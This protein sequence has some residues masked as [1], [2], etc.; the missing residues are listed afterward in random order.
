M[1]WR[2]LVIILTV[3][4]SA[5]GSNQSDNY[6]CIAL[7]LGEPALPH[8]DRIVSDFID[9]WIKG[10]RIEAHEQQFS[11]FE[12]AELEQIGTCS[13]VYVGSQTDR[14]S[15][16]P[17]VLCGSCDRGFTGL[18]LGGG[19]S[20]AS[21]SHRGNLERLPHLIAHE[22]GHSVGLPHTCAPSFMRGAPD[23]CD[24]YTTEYVQLHP[25]AIMQHQM[26]AMKNGFNITATD[27]Q[28]AG[29]PR[30]DK[31]ARSSLAVQWRRHS[32]GCSVHE[33]RGFKE[34]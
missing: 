32:G 26:E 1:T 7:A 18:H 4:L 9:V 3:S 14:M 5:C 10:I 30:P 25:I 8:T 24:D 34:N 28:T 17:S 2:G 12:D 13:T 21:I 31:S 15:S 6:E 33:V 27:G 16:G 29:I 22:V 20:L 23:D 19:V 11:T